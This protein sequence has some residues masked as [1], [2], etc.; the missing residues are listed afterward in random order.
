MLFLY[1]GSLTLIFI[2]WARRAEWHIVQEVSQLRELWILVPFCILTIRCNTIRVSFCLSLRFD[3][4]GKTWFMLQEMF[5]FFVITLG[6]SSKLQTEP[7]LKPT[8]TIW[9]SK[10]VKS[11]NLNV[12]GVLSTTTTTFVYIYQHC[13]ETK[14]GWKIRTPHM[15]RGLNSHNGCQNNGFYVISSWMHVN[16]PG[17]SANILHRK[18]FQGKLWCS[19]FT[20]R[21]SPFRAHLQST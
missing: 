16:A 18:T 6:G 21:F 10:D 14:V 3:P 19:I 4:L 17:W 11:L 5:H 7:H 20:G 1:V 8:G 12:L 2:I 9:Y 15:K 13:R